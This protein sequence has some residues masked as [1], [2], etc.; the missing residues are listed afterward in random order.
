MIKVYICKKGMAESSEDFSSSS[1]S[2]GT[3]NIKFN[4]KDDDNIWSEYAEITLTI[5]PPENQEKQKPTAT[6][7]KPNPTTTTEAISGE[8]I[9]FHGIGTDS[10]GTIVEYNWRSSKDSILSNKSTF[11]KSDL[12]VGTHIIY[13]KVQDDKGE[14]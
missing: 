12:S 11:T 13:F 5:N 8:S 4:V 3:H 1:L 7:I 9:Y 14:W 10:D 6:I 2:V